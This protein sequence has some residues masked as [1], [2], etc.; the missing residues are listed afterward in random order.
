MGGQLTVTSVEG[1]G[2]QFVFA[3]TVPLLPTTT[4][5][6]TAAVT[7]AQRATDRSASQPNATVDASPLLLPPPA[8]LAALLDMALKGELPRLRKQI[9]QSSA[10]NA[11]Y[12]PFVHK[13]LRLLDAYDEEGIVALLQSYAVLDESTT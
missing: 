2:S 4:D 10:A 8:E 3:L 7:A 13:L 6:T 1:E 12:Q 11:A 5:A 9:E